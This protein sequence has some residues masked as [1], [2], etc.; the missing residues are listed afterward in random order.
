MSRSAADLTPEKALIWRVVHR[1]NLPWMLDHG[2]NCANSSMQDPDYV[3]IGLADLIEERRERIVPL[4]PAG[5]LSDY[6]PFYF[7]PFSPMVYRIVTGR[8]VPQRSRAELCFLVTSL[9]HLLAQGL[10]FLIADRHAALNAAQFLGGIG[11]LSRLDWAQ[12]QVRDFARN[13]ENPEAF[14]RYQA[15]AL[16]YRHLPLSGLQGIVCHD[17]TVRDSIRGLV[18]S[19]S[20]DLRVVA[21]PEWYL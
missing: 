3:Q 17:T 18:A 20:L 15:E 5:Q 13:P 6:V 10:R 21:R 12:W 4:A 14:E 8:G 9:H 11:D 7:T 1:D 2:V 19:R 16:V